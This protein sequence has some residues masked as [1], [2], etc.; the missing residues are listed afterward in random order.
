MLFFIVD[1]ITIR[2]S[3]YL[4]SPL[5]VNYYYFYHYYDP[6]CLLLDILT[7]LVTIYGTNAFKKTDIL[8]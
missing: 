1:S 4:V 6:F 2:L 3:L 7:F 8:L 5:S